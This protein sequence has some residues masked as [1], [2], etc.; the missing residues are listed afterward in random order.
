MSDIT[1]AIETNAGKPKKAAVD[2][3]SVEQHTLPEQIE[4]DKYLR[5]RTAATRNKLPVRFAKIQPGPP[6]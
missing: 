4:A 1:D 5:E 6:Q 3:Q 2:G